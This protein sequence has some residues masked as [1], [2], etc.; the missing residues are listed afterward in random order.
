MGGSLTLWGLSDDDDPTPIL[1]LTPGN[2]N[3]SFL[4]LLNCLAFQLRNKENNQTI[5]IL[6]WKG[7]F[8]FLQNTYLG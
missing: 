2:V 3:M 7:H 6:P 8:P 1:T 5:H 4:F